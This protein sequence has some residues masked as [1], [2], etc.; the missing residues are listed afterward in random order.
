MNDGC[1][2]LAP[3]PVSAAKTNTQQRHSFVDPKK[4]VPFG[5]LKAG[6]PTACSGSPRQVPC[7]SPGFASCS[8]MAAAAAFDVLATTA[9]TTAHGM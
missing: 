5:K 9:G 8:L 2:L 3:G 1:E 4:R 6:T 7:P